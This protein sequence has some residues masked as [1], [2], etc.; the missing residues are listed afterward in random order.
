MVMDK[1][2]QIE[3]VLMP[4]LVE[5]A[6]RLSSILVGMRMMRTMRIVQMGEILEVALLLDQV[7]AFAQKKYNVTSSKNDFTKKENLLWK[8]SELD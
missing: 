7:M 8:K 2:V 3:V 6:I 5:I 4:M 1:V